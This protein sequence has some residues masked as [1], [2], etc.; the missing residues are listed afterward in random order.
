MTGKKKRA[1]LT[2]EALRGVGYFEA[3]GGTRFRLDGLRHVLVIT[4][5]DGREVEIP[6]QEYLDFLNGLEDGVQRT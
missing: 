2:L 4:A 5:P 6:E 3:S 1:T